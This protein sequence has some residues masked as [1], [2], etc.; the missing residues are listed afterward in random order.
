MKNNVET[1][2]QM[3]E[4]TEVREANNKEK[5]VKLPDNIFL[6]T[7]CG[8]VIVMEATSEKAYIKSYFS[9]VKFNSKEPLVNPRRTKNVKLPVSI[10]GKV[11]TNTMNLFI[12]LTKSN[13]YTRL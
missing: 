2:V 5:E 8:D 3:N 9:G 6:R 7:K 11:F 12:E 4:N 10:N 1:N 13:G